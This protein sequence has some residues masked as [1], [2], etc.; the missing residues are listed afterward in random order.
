MEGGREEW[1]GL[2][3]RERKGEMDGEGGREGGDGNRDG[4]K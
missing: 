2:R 1:M 4:F 3:E